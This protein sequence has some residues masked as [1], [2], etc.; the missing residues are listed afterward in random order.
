MCF[1]TTVT[2]IDF[3]SCWPLNILRNL[4]LVRLLFKFS[5]SWFFLQQFQQFVLLDYCVLQL[6]LRVGG[7]VLVECHLGVVH[8]HPGDLRCDLRVKLLLA[9]L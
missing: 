9:L 4:S 3:H 7:E 5:G 2:R 6:L 1:Q 8:F